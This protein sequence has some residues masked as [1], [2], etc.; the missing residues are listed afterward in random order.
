MDQIEEVNKYGAMAWDLIIAYGPK[1]VLAIV[2]LV[3]GLWII[4]IFGR[5][6]RSVLKKREIDPSLT[7]FLSSLLVSILKVLL[8]LSILSMVGIEVTSF[9]AILGAAGFAVGFALQGSLQNFAGGVM[10]LIFKPFKVGDFIEVAGYAG[11]V[12]EIQIFVTIL[13]TGDNKTILIPN[14]TVSSSSM[15]NYSKEDHRRVDFTVGIGY[16]DSMKDAKEILLK[17]ANADERIRR[18]PA[19]PFVGVA[20]LGDSSV[21]IAFRVWVNSEHYWPVHF[22]FTERIKDELDAAGIS[23]PFPQTEVTIVNPQN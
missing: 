10:I 12:K 20:S 22:D 9:V 2:T 21:N 18:E 15:V 6:F 5:K 14:G 3:I 17:I 4:G 7:P 16:G 8:V 23:I 13:T 19:E 11:V 1:V